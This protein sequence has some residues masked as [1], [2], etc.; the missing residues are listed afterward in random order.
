MNLFTKIDSYIDYNNHYSI[1]KGLET[2]R[3][4]F[5]KTVKYKKTDY[6]REVLF[7]I[8]LVYDKLNT[9]HGDNVNWALIIKRVSDFMSHV[10]MRL[11][12]DFN[13]PEINVENDIVL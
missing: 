3:Q 9:M 10:S 7:T 11:K 2:M 1:R 12:N 6:A 13:V 8:K 5:N 4:E